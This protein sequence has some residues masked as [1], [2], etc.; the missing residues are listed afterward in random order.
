MPI[1]NR[2][3]FPQQPGNLAGHGL[4]LR[5][6]G[7]P[8]DHADRL[9]LARRVRDHRKRIVFGVAE[10]VGTIG[11]VDR[12][13][14][15]IHEHQQLV[16][17]AVTAGNRR[18][19]RRFRPQGVDEC[20]G[21]IEHGDLGIPEPVNRLLAVADDE[22]RGRDGAV[23]EPFAGRPRADQLADQPPL[24]AAGVLELV[25]EHVLVT[26]FEAVPASRE[27]LHLAQQLERAFEEV[28]EIKHAVLVERATIF[29]LGD[30]EQPADAAGQHEI[31]V[32][33]ERLDGGLHV[34]AE[35]EHDRLVPFVIGG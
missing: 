28:R 33:A 23:T 12:D 15:I 11:L 21:R 5:A 24:R 18:A 20:R 13:A 17:R 31:D 29:V 25:D 1:A 34:R 7:I 6:I 30:G 27:L 10:R 16:D 3:A 26:R 22:N 19:R 9:S 32:L 2:G 8:G 4:C 14:H 35:A